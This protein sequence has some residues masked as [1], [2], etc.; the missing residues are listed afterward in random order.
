[1]LPDPVPTPPPSHESTSPD[2]SLDGFLGYTD[3]TLPADVDSVFPVDLLSDNTAA[4]LRAL[5]FSDQLTVPQSRTFEAMSEIITKHLQFAIK[6]FTQAPASMVQAL[7]T[8][9]SHHNLYQERMPKSIRDAQAACALYMAKTPINTPVIMRS[10]D[11]YCTDLLSSPTPTT[12]FDALAHAQSLLLYQIIRLFDGD[13]RSRSSAERSITALET[14]AISLL[15]H[16]PFDEPLLPAPALPLTPLGP[17]KMFWKQWLFH[18]SARRTM[19]FIFFFLQA[20]RMVSGG[21]ILPCDGKLWLVHSWTMSAHLW[22]AK[23]PVEFAQAWKD[24]NHFVVTNAMFNAVL[25]EAKADDVDLFGKML[26]SALM[27]Q[28][29]ADAWLT[30][31]GGSLHEG[32]CV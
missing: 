28:D 16:V 14:A 15:P 19:L 30:E 29:E 6:V 13:I 2:S 10:I 24:R 1:M 23:T 21:K 26:I 22:K 5:Q 20:Y 8:P 17:T 31:R 18:E 4:A 7:S 12:A 27:G 3:P 25:A 11:S 32:I 9:W